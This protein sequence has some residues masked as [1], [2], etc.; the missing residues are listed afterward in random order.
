MVSVTG[1]SAG[2]AG[3]S[4]AFLAMG[5]SSSELLSLGWWFC[6]PPSYLFGILSGY[7]DFKR[8]PLML[9]GE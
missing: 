6:L 2:F 8:Q 9:Y 3:S 1:K 5:R 7:P 4:T